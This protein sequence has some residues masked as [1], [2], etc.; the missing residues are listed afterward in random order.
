V[1]LNRRFDLPPA[2]WQDCLDAAD[3][4]AQNSRMPLATSGSL[5]SPTNRSNAMSTGQILRSAI[6]AA[7]WVLPTPMSWAENQPAQGD[8]PQEFAVRLLDESGSPV[9][10]A[11]VGLVAGWGD[12]NLAKSGWEYVSGPDLKGV[13]VTSNKDGMV[14]FAGDRDSLGNLGLT[15]RHAKRAL[16]AAEKLDATSH[17]EVYTVVMK[18]EC[19]VH[20][21]LTC[22]QLAAHPRFKNQPDATLGTGVE[23]SVHGNLIVEYWSKDPEFE[24]YLPPG[25][26]KLRGRDEKAWTHWANASFSVAPGQQ[27]LDLGEIDRP[28]TAIKSLEGEQA[29]ELTDVVAWKNSEP[30]K[31]SDL[32]GRVVLLEF[33]G[34]WCHPCVYRMPQVFELHDKF[35]DKGLTVVGIH[36]DLGDDETEKVDSLKILDERLQDSRKELWKGR[37]IPFPVAMIPGIRTPYGPGIQGGARGATAAR[38]GVMFFPSQVLI[39]RQGN[40]VGQ[41]FP[42]DDNVARLEKLLAEP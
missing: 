12:M 37:D 11:Q 13:N 35:R 14:R 16:A 40:V 29:P 34:Y 20:G 28:L 41:F 19:R 30:L 2:N 25:D 39:D 21:R 33:F 17:A 7:L 1:L 32:K 4:D 23:I 36:V 10:G 31:L 8:P 22:K 18:P 27:T 6:F 15:A 9:A 5:A 24:C 42:S 3:A 26:Y 38:Y